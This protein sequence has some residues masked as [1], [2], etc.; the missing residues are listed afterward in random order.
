MEIIAFSPRYWCEWANLVQLV[1]LLNARLV[2]VYLKYKRER[3]TKVEV[4]CM[5]SQLWIL[6]VQRD[7]PPPPMCFYNRVGLQRLHEMHCG[8]VCPGA[9]QGRSWHLAACSCAHA[10][11][12]VQLG[13]QL[14]AFNAHCH[15]VCVGAG[16]PCVQLVGMGPGGKLL[17]V[18]RIMCLHAWS[19][20]VHIVGVVDV[21]NAFA[22]GGLVVQRKIATAVCHGH[23]HLRS[24][25]S[26]GDMARITITITIIIIH[27][28]ATPCA[29]R[30]VP[31][32]GSD[33]TTHDLPRCVSLAVEGR[34]H[35]F[36]AE[37]RRRRGGN[38]GDKEPHTACTPV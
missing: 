23:C 21:C 11:W 5:F 26:S 7:T 24:P 22:H 16:L 14:G 19:G 12:G 13:V 18:G 32:R 28:P 8:P 30:L 4:L 10:H 1:Q 37:G 36:R 31:T 25:R 6:P 38:K 35:L 33:Y 27:V 3:L 20:S 29:G 9:S 15:T 17:S 34:M 2:T